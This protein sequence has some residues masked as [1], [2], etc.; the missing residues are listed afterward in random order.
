MERRILDEQILAKVAPSGSEEF[1]HARAQGRELT[2][3]DAT[4]RAL[5]ALGD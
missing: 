2:L 4:A 5:A 1:E 3:T